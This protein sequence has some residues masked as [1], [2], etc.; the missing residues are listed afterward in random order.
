MSRADSTNPP[1]PAIP[2]PP[3]PAPRD[4]TP[5]ASRRAWNEPRVHFWWIVAI[6]LVLGAAF[7]AA[8]EIVSWNDDARLIRNGTRI[9][10]VV[11]LYGA[12]VK[13]RPIGPEDSAILEFQ[14]NGQPVV[15]T[16]QRITGREDKTFAGDTIPIYV[17]PNDSQNWTARSAP[18]WVG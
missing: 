18:A 17:D 3:P 1:P 7:L 16:N 5:A 10:A 2:A 14:W 8:Q 9:D 4:V 15:L 11:W 12:R 6:G 13:G